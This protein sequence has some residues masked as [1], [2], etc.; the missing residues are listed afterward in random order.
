MENSEVINVI[1]MIRVLQYI[2]DNPGE[3]TEQIMVAMTRQFNERMDIT[4]DWM[5]HML[6]SYET[7]EFIRHAHNSER[8]CVWLHCDP[9]P[10]EKVGLREITV[11]VLGG[12]GRYCVYTDMTPEVFAKEL[13]A[14]MATGGFGVFTFGDVSGRPFFII[15]ASQIGAVAFGPEVASALQ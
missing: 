11:E 12:S 14:D 8:K 13:A 5:S 1:A 7:A 2:R 15:R 9:K 6:A 3:T 10:V 4:T